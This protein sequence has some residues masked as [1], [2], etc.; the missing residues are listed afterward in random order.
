MRDELVTA[1]WLKPETAQLIS[2]IEVTP[3]TVTFEKSMSLA[4]GDRQI[5]LAHLGRAHTD[6]DIVIT[7]DDVL[8]AGDLIEV[9]APPSFGDSFPAEWVE[10]LVL[11]APICRGPVVP[12]H[13][14]VV[15][16]DFV[17]FQTEEIR[18]AV[19]GEA[20]YSEA[21]TAAIAERLASTA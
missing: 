10:T 4:L 12:G 13:G 17:E 8:F 14:D 5:G 18:R 11:M 7:V 20:V 6:S 21:V 1:D 9:G 19:D 3:P 2:E 16:R 15:D